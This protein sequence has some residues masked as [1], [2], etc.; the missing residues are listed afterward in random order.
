MPHGALAPI[1]RIWNEAPA[2]L[3]ERQKDRMQNFPSFAILA[4]LVLSGCSVSGASAPPALSSSSALSGGGG[5]R[6]LTA[7]EKRIITESLSENIRD[8]AK[9]KY[10]WAPFPASAPANGQGH[11]C[12]AVNAKSPHAAYSGLQ[13]YLVQV[14]IANGQIV[15]SVVGTIA[16]GADSRI[17]KNICAK[18]GLNP[19]D[20]V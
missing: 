5:G 8:P 20:A 2:P 10:L 16:G 13:P 12:A 15:S 4:G 1:Q 18:H 19:G 9:A 6:A 11:Y 7:D 14:Q 17:V 3:P